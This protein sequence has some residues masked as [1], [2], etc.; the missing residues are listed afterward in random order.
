MTP[1]KIL[2]LSS[3]PLFLLA[4]GNDDEDTFSINAPDTYAFT[5]ITD[6]SAAS[7][8]DYKE[9]TTR[10][11]LIKELEYLIGSDYLQEVGQAQGQAAA[12]EL[13][14]RIY[15]KGT[16]DVP[17]NLATTNLY[18][19]QSEPTPIM[20]LT[21]SSDLTS[22]QQNFSD[23]EPNVNLQN[24]L[25]GIKKDLFFRNDNDDTYGDLIGWYINLLSDED[26]APDRMI[27]QWFGRIATLASDSDPDTR[28]I[29]GNQ[30]YQQLV[31]V[32]LSGAI[33][34]FNATQFHLHSEQGMQANNTTGGSTTYYSD[35][36]H[37]W[38]LA[39]GYYGASRDI[40]NLKFQ[41]VSSQAD[42]DSNQDNV[43]DLYSEVNFS[44]ALE[45]SYRDRDGP[46]GDI[47]F[48]PITTQSQLNGRQLIDDQL[49]LI[50]S[51][52]T[53][54]LE[55][56]TETLLQ[57]WEKV[58]AATI[59]HYLNTTANEAALFKLNDFEYDEQYY[60]TQWSALK[61]H[62]LALQFSPF[63]TLSKQELI[64]IHT[65]LGTGPEISNPNF[66]NNQ[67]T[68][69]SNIRSTL[70]ERFEFSNESAGNW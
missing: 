46:L 13:L 55:S 1:L 18:N 21:F 61:A 48:T 50:P 59:L 65:D 39:M 10:N 37:Q 43:I 20:G 53:E 70:V 45:A 5:S 64:D 33:N 62:A 69:F 31:T 7:S 17:D 2:T 6:P 68:K 19:Q 30:D 15:I 67:F 3:L 12:L 32:F 66:L 47:K 54:P 41:Q 29:E 56:Q 25:A 14:N 26:E 11:I 40:K 35:L 36:Q 4:C 16:L 57:N 44:Y 58:I 49:N 8:V 9:A 63:G 28:F 42:N 34:Y 27:E 24:H 38:D 52:T 60:I 23:L 22:L 51:T